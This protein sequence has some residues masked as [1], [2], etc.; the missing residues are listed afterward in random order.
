MVI[1]GALIN[2][3][4]KRFGFISIVNGSVGCSLVCTT[5]D[6]LSLVSGWGMTKYVDLDVAVDADADANVL[7]WNIY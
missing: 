2:S 4:D 6:V 1:Y 5:L 3:F 7:F